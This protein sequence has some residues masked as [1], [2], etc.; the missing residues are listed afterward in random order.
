MALVVLE[1]FRKVQHKDKDVETV[2]MS[3]LEDFPFSSK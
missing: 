1:D 3:K 2:I